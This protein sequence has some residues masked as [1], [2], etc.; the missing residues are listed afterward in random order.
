MRALILSAP[1]GAGHDAAARGIAAELAARGYHV[2]I[3]NGLALLDG[4]LK[5]FILGTYRLQLERAEW[6]WRLLYRVTRSNLLIRA[7]GVALA[8]LGG[9]RLVARVEQSRATLV[10]S[11]YPLVSAP[12]AALRR[13]GKLSVRCATMVTDVDPHPAWIHSSLDANLTVGDAG[14]GCIAARPP[15]ADFTPPP[16]TRSAIRARLGLSSTARVALIVGGAWGVGDLEG[17]ARA[18]IHAKLCPIVVCG[19]NEAL[20]A[21]IRTA[22]SLVDARVLGYSAELPALMAA[23]DVL[24]QNAGGLTCL[25]AFNVG[26]PVVMYNPLAGHGKANARRMERHGLVSLARDGASLTAILRSMTFWATV[27]TEQAGRARRLY[28]RP[29]CGEL[30]DAIPRRRMATRRLRQRV[31]ATATVAVCFAAFGVADAPAATAGTFHRAPERVCASAA[32]PAPVLHQ[33]RFDERRVTA[34]AA[35]I[36]WFYVS[37]RTSS[38]AAIRT[39]IAV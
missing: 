25:E 23:S 16:G 30:F 28:D 6:S 31:R 1:V 35:V 14:R 5:R 39:A 19:H 10:V 8:M 38:T 17:A 24:I 33:S 15:I 18:A 26:L 2:E 27:S 9:R 36:T 20:A 12:L 29:S 11:T 22:P 3:D 37:R 32:N 4:R 7:V 13:S 21:R 34:L